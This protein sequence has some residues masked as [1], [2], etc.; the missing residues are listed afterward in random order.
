LLASSAENTEVAGRVFNVATG[1]RTDLFQT[2]QILKKLTGY[3]G[4]VKYA[5]GRSGD[6]K[7][8]LADIALAEKHLGYK[9]AVDFEEGLARR[10]A[11]VDRESGR[12][13]PHS[14]TWRKPERVIKSES[15]CSQG[16][17]NPPP[18]P[19]VRLSS[20]AF[21]LCA[22]IPTRSLQTPTRTPYFFRAAFTMSTGIEVRCRTSCVVLPKIK[23]PTRRWP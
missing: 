8:S 19:G 4:D 21:P 1:R 18:R 23:S 15:F 2:F 7:H 22:R 10:K 14:K 6:V 9:P 16:T 12:G 20:A 3:S 13:Q 5:P 17:H 11:R